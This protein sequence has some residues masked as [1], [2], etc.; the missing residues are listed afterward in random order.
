[1]KILLAGSSHTR[2]IFPHVKV[3]MKDVALVTKLPRDAGRT[4]EILNSLQEW[5]LEAQDVVHLYSG[6]RDLAPRPDGRPY[7]ELEQY[8]RNLEKIVQEVLRRTSAKIVLSNIPPVTE[9]FL[10]ADPDRNR[11]IELYNAIIG[12]IAEKNAIP[13]FDFWRFISSYR[14]GAEIYNDGLHFTRGVYR[15]YGRVL[16]N[17]FVALLG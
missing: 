1:M 10:E 8:R 17:S 6:H 3:F 4:D 16:A 7:V 15:D 2:F 12:E 13:V 14:G 5:P 11:R 9:G